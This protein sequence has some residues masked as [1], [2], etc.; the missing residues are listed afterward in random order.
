ICGVGPA[1]ATAGATGGIALSDA[2][3]VR[4]HPT[5]SV[6]IPIGTHPHGQSHETTFA[7]IA[8][9]TLGVPYD[10]IEIRYGDT[11]EGPAFGYGTYG[12]RSLA[13]GGMAVRSSCIKI[14]EKAQ[15]IAAHLLE[16]A[17]S[18]M[19]FEQGRFHVRGNPGSAKTMG[20]IAFAAYGP[21]LPEGD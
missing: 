3:Y 16:V 9:D 1:A 5:G 20:E 14:V 2:S 6:Q 4:V 21:S 18:D 15:R 12:S 17:P 8:A 19:A 10:S 7:Q 11:A 13:V